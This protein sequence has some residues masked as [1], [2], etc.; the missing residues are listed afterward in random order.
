MLDKIIVGIDRDG[1]IIFDRGWPGSKWP[2]EAF[3]LKPGVVEGIKLLNSLGIKTAV[4]T[5]QSG[6]ARSKVK[7]EAIPEVNS[8]LHRLLAQSEAFVDAWFYCEHVPLDYAKK[9]SLSEDNPFVGECDDYKP[10]CGMLKKA[11][12]KFGIP[13]DKATIYVIGD[14]VSDVLTGINASGKGVFVQSELEQ[15]DINEAEKL[16]T[17]FPNR[18]FITKDFLEGVKW[19][20]K[21]S[22][23]PYSSSI[24]E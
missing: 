22:R 19:I 17:H 23:I 6:P 13:F 12:L 21:D 8:A 2:D 20:L 14:R 10:K 1:T 3:E 4:I 16:L 9:H 18:V 7:L 11:A 5:N 24:T 15:S